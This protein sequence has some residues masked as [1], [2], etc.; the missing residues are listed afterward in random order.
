M[1]SA[2]LATA[3]SQFGLQCVK[4]LVPGATELIKPA[5]ELGQGTGIQRVDP[6]STLSPDL[7]DA[8]VTEYPEM[9]RGPRL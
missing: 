8:M 7:H 9:L 2:P 3:S 4:R 6:T 1:T 5:V